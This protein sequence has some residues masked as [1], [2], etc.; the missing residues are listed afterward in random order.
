MLLLLLLSAVL[1][2]SAL[3]GLLLSVVAVQCS[4]VYIQYIHN[5]SSQ[6]M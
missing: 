4:S 2:L 5:S 3:L 6:V 1:A